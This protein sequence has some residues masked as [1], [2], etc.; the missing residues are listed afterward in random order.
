MSTSPNSNSIRSIGAVEHAQTLVLDQNNEFHTKKKSG[1]S[2]KPSGGILKRSRSYSESRPLF[3]SQ[4]IPMS[5]EYGSDGRQFSPDHSIR[6]Q[7]VV[8]YVGKIDVVEGRVP[9]TFRLTIFWYDNTADDELGDTESVSS[10]SQYRWAMQGRQQ[11]IQKEMTQ[12]TGML[13]IKTVEVPAVSILNVTTFNTIG[14][15]EVSLLDESKKLM[16]WSC[17]YR[18]TLLQEDLKVDNFPHDQHDITLKLAILAHRGRGQFWDRSVWRLALATEE[19]SRGSTRV[20]HGLIVDQVKIPEF[21]L[22]KKA[23]CFNIRPLLHGPAGDVG[24]GRD[25]YLEVKLSVLRESG[26]YDNNIIP[27]LAF[28]N[29]V[30]VS[31][32]CL[33]PEDFFQRGLLTLQISFLEIGIRMTTDK[34]LPSV[35]YQIKIQAILNRYFYGLLLLVLESCLVFE[36]HINFGWSNRATSMVDWISAVASLA[37]NAYMFLRYYYD[38]RTA[39]RR[40]NSEK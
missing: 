13:P 33:Y 38:A 12:D 32:L 24:H 34:H 28:L 6:F 5:L 2:K 29:L 35:S 7:V 23:L 21:I 26:Y 37:S 18:A 31:I 4:S 10:R 40:L 20:P 3:R 30:A 22:S 15:P 1:G 11:A 25:N 8:W 36:L 17:M 9:M 27:L 19:D 16:R 14:S 39:R